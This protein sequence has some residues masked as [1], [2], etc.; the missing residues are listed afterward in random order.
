MK[1]SILKLI[2]F[3]LLLSIFSGCSEDDEFNGTTI[4]MLNVVETVN[5]GDNE[6][7]EVEIAFSEAVVNPSLIQITVSDTREVNTVPAFEPNSGVIVLPVAAGEIST[8]FEISYPDEDLTG[9]F[10]IEFTITSVSGDFKNIGAG[11]FLLNVLDNDFFISPPYTQDFNSNC[12][13]MEPDVREGWEVFNVNSEFTWT[14]SGS[15]RGNSGEF[16]DYALEASNFNSPDGE[17]SEDWLISPKIIKGGINAV[18]TSIRFSV[19]RAVPSRFSIP[20]LI[21]LKK[22]LITLP[23]RL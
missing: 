20:R 11:T 4:T 12:T 14:C 15:G 1:K 10:S 21:P 9:D 18:L 3:V 8:S 7:I 5:E 13:V 16:G 2:S 23:G 6:T 19:I 17:P 22:T